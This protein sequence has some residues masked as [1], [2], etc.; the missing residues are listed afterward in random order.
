MQPAR[1]A[2][3]AA[4]RPTCRRALIPLAVVLL[5]HGPARA[6]EPAPLQPS[7]SLMP[8]VSGDAARQ[9]PILLLAD[10]VKVRP[11]LDAVAEGAV[12]FRR[13][14]TLIRSDQ[15]RY[16]SASD[17]ALA[18]GKVFIGRNGVRYRGT[19][20][21]LQVQRFEGFFLQPEFEFDRLGAGG[22]AERIDFIDS[23]RSRALNAIYTSCPREG[24]GEPDWL[25]RTDRVKLDFE[26]N[27]GVAEGA[28]LQ[29]LGVPILGLPV[30]SFPLTDDRKSG[31]LPPTVGLDSRSGFELGVPYYWNIA[32]DRDATFT[33]TALTRRGLALDSEFRYLETRH[34]GRLRLHLLPD[35]R[36]VG[37][38]RFAWEIDNA[39][40][41]GR[42]T[43]YSARLLR[44]SDDN[45]WKDFSQ[46][47]P[48]SSPR[49]L[50]QD[51]QLQRDLVTAL[52]P[53]QAYA[54]LQ[55][56][57]VLQTGSGS[58]LIVAPYQRS[59]QLGLRLAPVLPAGLRAT[60]E[61]EVNHFT[62]TSRTADPGA[63]NGWR[64]H[65][66]GQ[67][68]RHF[69]W[70]GAWLT[71]RLTLNAASYSYDMPGLDRQRSTRVIPT[72][73]VDAGMVLERDTIW[74]GRAQRQT[75]EPRLL[76]VNT[77]FRDQAGLPNFDAAE[78]DFNAV[79]IY[80]ESAFS[81]I[82]RVSDAHQVTAG[83]TTR[84]VDTSTGAETLRLGLAQRI[85][86]RDQQVVLAGPVLSQRF[87]DVLV[88]GSSSVFN[89]WKLDAA[90]Q[91]N[92]DSKRVVRSI[93]GVRYQ[94]G[95][96]R[97]LSA[98]YRL[99]RD[100]S[101]QVEVGWQWPLWRGKAAPV[102]AAGGCGGTLYAVGRINYS[103]RDSR[104]TD[105]LIGAEY[106]TGCWIARIVSERLSTGRAEATTRLQLQLE[107]VGLSRLGS[108][109][110]QALK[111][112]V[113]GYRLLR[114]PRSIP[115]PNP[116]P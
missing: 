43:R 60:L 35:D 90:L 6:V 2:L 50:G 86:L 10:E 66:L 40:W 27:E 31:W 89:P 108:N 91:Y 99:A 107:L 104:M 77:P 62:R 7:T 56:W 70:P 26:T 8:P 82:D 22:R 51:V 18:K 57:Q 74:F 15:M 28:V 106:D 5:C 73:S 97:T 53:L 25:L 20:L 19:E 113:P 79:S 103:L 21:Q 105:A 114:E 11:D 33:P 75:L 17:T 84:L 87:S 16:D 34:N 32:P 72:T 12:E 45:Y 52:G 9:L 44:V 55:H 1:A 58:D 39:G 49:L 76:Y 41:L 88:E 67:L 94:P 24:G 112:N 61:T 29:F 115:F 30:L 14:G 47:V 110:L 37:R 54:R 36:T 4:R 68:T 63:P 3:V 23:D 78:R 116:E 93:F 71:P 96:F 59:P 80:A 102:G 111:D 100:L 85:R 98:G 48:A 46:I 38:T 69:T 64:W 95:P 81:G 42:S 83:I 109:P 92:P 65:A 101:E 13:A